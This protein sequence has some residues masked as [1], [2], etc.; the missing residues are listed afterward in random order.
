MVPPRSK[1][2]SSGG[3]KAYALASARARAKVRDQPF[4]TDKTATAAAAA[5]PAT[6]VHVHAVAPKGAAPSIDAAFVL[7]RA[8]RRVRV[9]PRGTPCKS[10]ST[11]QT[12]RGPKNP[13]CPCL[14]GAV[15]RW[16]T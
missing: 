10:S 6:N 16:R 13:L 1:T 14:R 11:P 7:G 8:Q 2:S 5:S 9:P 4:P 3:A 15:K 12:S